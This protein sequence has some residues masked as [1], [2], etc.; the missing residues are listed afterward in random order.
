[1]KLDP[2]PIPLYHQLERALRDRI[3]K[4]EFAPGAALP[5]EER[6]CSEYG[7]SRI[8]VRRALD[9]LIAQGLITRRHGVG[10]FVTE[11]QDGV[12]SVQL[13]GSL[14]EFLA[15][16]GALETRFLSIATIDPPVE[17]VEAL[18]LQPREKAIRL[19]LTNL[20]EGHAV[21]YL[22]LYFPV[23]A[24]SAVSRENIE[25]GTPTIRMIERKLNLRIERAEQ[26]IEADFAGEKA[27]RHLGLKPT[28]PILRVTRVY[29]AADGRPVEAVFVRN[30]PKRYRY[31][32]DFKAG[33]PQ[34]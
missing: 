1:M 29:Y 9:A 16:A 28:D 17:A 18:R 34:A 2:G 19:E 15:T 14:D 12:R 24:G 27:A 10:S 6:L 21:G 8:T 25:A 33:R 30:H 3:H 4:A 11:R 31:A 26:M 7:V 23:W 13:V 20:L 32:I 5:T 22:E